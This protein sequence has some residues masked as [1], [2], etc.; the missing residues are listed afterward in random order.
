MLCK[1]KVRNRIQLAREP[2]QMLLCG[3][4]TLSFAPG[5]TIYRTLTEPILPP[6]DGLAGTTILTWGGIFRPRKACGGAVVPLVATISR[7][8]R[9]FR[10][11]K[12]RNGAYMPFVAPIGV[13]RFF[14]YFY[15]GTTK[16][17]DAPGD[18]RLKNTDTYPNYLNP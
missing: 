6:N 7:K 8:T 1:S 4:K 16:T 13:F 2:V 12:E 17:P 5:A 11:R 14:S 3:A 9:K 18:K 15:E 10:P